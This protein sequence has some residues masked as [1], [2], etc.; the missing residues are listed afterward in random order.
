MSLA[1]TSFNSNYRDAIYHLL[2][3]A[4]CAMGLA[5]L[6]VKPSEFKAS[7][8]EPTLIPPQQIEH[9]TFGYSPVIADILWVRSIQS[10]EFC[11]HHLEHERYSEDLKRNLVMCEK[12]WIFQ[13]L[14]SVTRLEPRYQ[15]AYTRGAVGLS[16]IVN[17]FNGAGILFSRGVEALPNNWNI[18]FYGAYHYAVELKDP[19][20]AATYMERAALAGAPNWAMLLAARFYDEAGQAESGL[21]VLKQFYGATPF[22]EWPTRAQERYRELE[23]RIKSAK[24]RSHK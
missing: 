7:Q 8:N 13:M 4:L 16:V 22:E 5:A 9:F 14:D 20:I 6:P 1:A 2:G 24:Q 10:F 21:E 17:D 15:I 3:I 19:A 18:A 23:A 12:G 11:G